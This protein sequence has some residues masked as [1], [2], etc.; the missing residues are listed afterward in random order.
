MKTD[1][2]LF[3]AFARGDRQAFTEL[4]DRYQDR[5]YGYI[6]RSVSVQQV[7][8]DLFQDVWARV[9]A[10]RDRFSHQQRFRSW[11]FTCAHN[12]IVDHYRR[13]SRWKTEELSPSLESDK[14]EDALQAVQWTRI[15]A[16]VET[17]PMEQKQAFF[18]RESF[19]S[20]VKEIAE[21]QGCSLEAA[22]S[23]LRYAYARIRESL[24]VEA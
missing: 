3:A 13:E 21:V 1:D 23:R 16:V 9:I 8:E 6:Y 4:Y 24:G 15:R 17:L 2:E 19:D 12:V 18:M 5:V 11:L 20:S 14:V 10:A 22:K 7:A